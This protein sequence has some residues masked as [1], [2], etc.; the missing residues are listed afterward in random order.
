MSGPELDEED[1]ERRAIKAYFRRFEN[2]DQPSTV[3]V[4]QRGGLNYVV[5]SNVN[6]T[7]AVYRVLNDDT[8]LRFLRRWPAGLCQYP[9]PPHR[10]R[11]GD[12]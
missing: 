10:P 6:G 1:L 12:R 7:L 9:Q 2:P 3:E 8:S 5:L 11:G 4:E